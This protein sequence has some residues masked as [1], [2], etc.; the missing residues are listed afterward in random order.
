MVVPLVVLVGGVALSMWLTGDGNIAAGDGSA[1]VLYAAIAA[2]AALATLLRIEGTF[3]LASI[4]RKLLAGMAQFLE[5]ALLIVLALALGDINRELGTGLYI[6]QALQ[7]SMPT[8]V[9]PALVF[10]TGAAMS[11][12]TGTSYGTF[13]NMV[14]IALPISAATSLS[15]ELMFGACIAGGV[16][17]DNCSPISDTTIVSAMSANVSAI[18]HAR[19]QLPYA[20]I[21]ASITAG[22]YLVLGFA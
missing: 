17:G 7:G 21:A 13:S 18:E 1:S 8:A 20:L 11:F 16:F 19:T 12:A 5:V 22:G 9:L 6:A 14:P 2:I 10:A 15:P 3:D 4:E